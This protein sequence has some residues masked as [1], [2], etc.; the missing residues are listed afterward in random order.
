ML[1][2]SGKNNFIYRIT[3][4]TLLLCSGAC[5]SSFDPTRDPSR[6]LPI[7]IEAPPP[8]GFVAF[9]ERHE[10]YCQ[11]DAGEQSNANS[12]R[13]SSV[14]GLSDNEEDIWATALLNENP[15]LT[16]T[17]R[18]TNATK[19]DGMSPAGQAAY[20]FQTPMLTFPRWLDVSATHPYHSLF[21]QSN[22]DHT[23][24]AKPV[25]K[26]AYDIIAS[27]NARINRRI[28]PLPD[29]ITH[30]TDELWTLPLTFR[31][32]RFGD[33][34]DYA[35]EKQQALL[36]HGIAPEAMFLA[37]VFSPRLGRHAVLIIRTEAGDYVLDNTTRAIKPWFETQYVW[38][39][40]QSPSNPLMWHMIPPE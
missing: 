36:Q 28:I 3:A 1:Y 34:E 37:T 25:S 7:G 11:H 30:G 8:P 27:V 16:A 23:S 38:A 35:L 32:G 14:T 4:V 10:E 5:A 19:E 18:T 39:S 31:Q 40:R 9:C 2:L 24:S 29:R 15:N 33:C 12:S 20:V 26:E 22:N 17:T 13:S 21:I 6:L